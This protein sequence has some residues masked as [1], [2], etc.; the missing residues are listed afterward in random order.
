MTARLPAL[1]LLVA[2]ALPFLAPEDA[3]AQCA[4]C[5]TALEQNPEAAAGFN[6]GILF[7]LGMP[8]LLFGI[9][10]SVVI[11]HRRARKTVPAHRPHAATDFAPARS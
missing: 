4:M 6:R 5:R 8:Y 11:R 9:G 2:I 10:A 1:A 7:L 3:A